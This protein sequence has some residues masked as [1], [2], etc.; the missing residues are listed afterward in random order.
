MEVL[1]T[2]RDLRPLPFYYGSIE[3]SIALGYNEARHEPITSVALNTI[4]QK[5]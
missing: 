1:I 5:N 2:K 4:I 3:A